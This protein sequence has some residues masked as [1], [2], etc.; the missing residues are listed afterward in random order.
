MKAR[1]LPLHREDVLGLTG[2]RFVAA[3]SVLLGHSL[4]TLTDHE[5][6]LGW[7]YWV[8]QSSGFGMTLFF[9]LSGFVIHYNYAALVKNEGWRGVGAYLWAR[10][11][12]LYPLFFLMLVV[13][14]AVSSRFRELLAGHPER[15]ESTLLALP[16]FLA[17]IHSWVY[18]PIQGNALVSAIGGGS[19]ITWSIST[20]W[21]FYFV[22]PCIAWLI[23]KP[24]RSRVAAALLA[25]WCVT[26]VA[27]AT[28]LF[29]RT[30]AI[31]AWGVSYFGSVASI[32]TNQQDSFVRW[33]LYLSPYLRIG[34]FVLGALL[35]QFYVLM[36]GRAARRVPVR[37]N[38]FL[39]R[40]CADAG[41]EQY[42]MA[43]SCGVFEGV[44]WRLANLFFS[45]V[46][47]VLSDFT[48]RAGCL[49]WAGRSSAST[50]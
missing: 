41:A 17:S 29:D 34:E 39:D 21:F 25:L 48:S 43:S 12:R 3:F 31:D 40:G 13:N 37:R 10:F 2:L 44:G 19:S 49:S 16:Y 20:E 32:D 42:L 38:R 45:L 11:A 47:P 46:Q 33:L 14:V 18:V 5:T 35:A 9:V 28:N 8:K 26:W 23:L 15:F 7:I 1:T 4:S 27:V 22:Y 30:P 36:R 24:R 50:V 6:P